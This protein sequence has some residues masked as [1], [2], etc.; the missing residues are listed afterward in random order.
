MICAYIYFTFKAQKLPKADYHLF[1]SN[2]GTS[3]EGKM[4]S[5]SAPASAAR[6]FV[7]TW[8][9]ES[10]TE[11]KETS[12]MVYPL[13]ASPVGLL[14]YTGDGFVSAQ[15]MI[16]GRKEAGADLWDVSHS[17]GLAELAA[18][19]IAYCGRFTVHEDSKQVVHTPTVALFPNL[20]DHAQPRTYSFEEKHLTLETL[21]SGTDGLP[22]RARLVWRKD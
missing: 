16:A 9:L 13:G 7:G 14:I 10:F 1:S 18:G 3:L 15:L 11:Y 19:Y 12:G 4:L 5:K 8:V 6:A 2:E 21:R 17:D 20:V 22:I